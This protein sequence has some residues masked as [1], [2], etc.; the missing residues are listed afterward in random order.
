MPGFLAMQLKRWSKGVG[1]RPP[2][3]QEVPP[4][5]A[6]LPPSPSCTHTPEP[7]TSHATTPR[8]HTRTLSQLFTPLLASHEQRRFHAQ[9]CLPNRPVRRPPTRLMMSSC[10]ACD[11]TA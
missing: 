4:N 7:S 8:A 3:R 2:G 1:M 6:R 9:W 5:W 11:V 10:W